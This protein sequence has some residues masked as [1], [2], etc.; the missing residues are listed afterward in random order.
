M[1]ELSLWLSNV[2]LD[3]CSQYQSVNVRMWFEWD[4]DEDDNDEE[5]WS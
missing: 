4:D 2:C 1:M 3:I 5:V